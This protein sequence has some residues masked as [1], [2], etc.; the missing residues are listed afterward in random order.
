M[1]ILTYGYTVPLGAGGWVQANTRLGIPALYFADGSVGV[2]Y[3]VGPA[4]ALSSSLANAAS[5]D[6]TEATK[7]GT[8][9]DTEQAN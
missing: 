6:L 2:A 3:S 9:I 5:W 8:V 7:C 1:S 4:T